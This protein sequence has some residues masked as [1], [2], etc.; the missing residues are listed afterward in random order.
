MGMVLI[1]SE[2]NDY[3]T[4]K[5]IEWLFYFGI[6][7]IVR[8]N[9]TDKIIIKEIDFQKKDFTFFKNEKCLNCVKLPMCFG[10]CVQ[11]YY[12]TKTGKSEFQC[13][14]DAAEISLESYVRDKVDIQNKLLQ[15]NEKI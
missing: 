4:D 5:V 3:Y 1:I 10:P 6:K 2:N 8:I 12:E 14:H 11:K 13:L 9:E 15:Q 7:E